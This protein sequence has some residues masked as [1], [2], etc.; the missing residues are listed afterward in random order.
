M[1]PPDTVNFMLA[2]LAGR[3]LLPHGG[4]AATAYVAARGGGLAGRPRGAG[5]VVAARQPRGNG[6]HICKYGLRV[7]NSTNTFLK[8]VVLE[9]KKIPFQQPVSKL[10]LFF[11]AYL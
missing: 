3:R 5:S 9:R 4:R 7:I 11:L 6:C 10:V 1:K 8:G 2:Y